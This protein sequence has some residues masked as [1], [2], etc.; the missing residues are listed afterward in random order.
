MNHQATDDEQQEKRLA[1]GSATSRP[2]WA[3]RRMFIIPK[4]SPLALQLDPLL[5]QLELSH[6]VFEAQPG[7]LLFE[8]N[9]L[10]TH[11]DISRRIVP[12][13]FVRQRLFLPHGERRNKGSSQ[14]QKRK[15]GRSK[16]CHIFS[17]CLHLQTVVG[18]DPNALFQQVNL[19][20]SSNPD[21]SLSGSQ[22]RVV[23]NEKSLIPI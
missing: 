11:L 23:S 21:I 16:D 12:V 19:R 7:S 3:A 10:E 18:T 2:P 1:S 17:N 8:G 6:L 5:F 15:K 22:I 14:N 4:R 9:L 13:G 20:T